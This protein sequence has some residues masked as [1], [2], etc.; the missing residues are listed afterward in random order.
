MRHIYHYMNKY[1]DVRETLAATA[2]MVGILGL[3]PMLIWL[4]AMGI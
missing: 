1:E 3:G 4:S 2:I